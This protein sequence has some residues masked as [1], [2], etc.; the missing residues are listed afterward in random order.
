MLALALLASGC[1][2]PQPCVAVSSADQTGQPVKRYDEFTRVTSISSAFVLT[3]DQEW[4]LAEER[5]TA[6][7]WFARASERRD[8]LVALERRKSQL[9]AG[10]R[11]E[12]E[13]IATRAQALGE[14]A[15]RLSTF[16]DAL[17]GRTETALA[18]IPIQEF[19]GVLDWPVRGRV[20]SGFGPRVDPASPVEPQRS[21]PAVGRRRMARRRTSGSAATSLP[22]GVL[23]GLAGLLEAVLLRF[24]LAGV[25]REEPGLLEKRP[26]LGVEL[27]E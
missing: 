26:L 25:A 1:R 2:G 10:T 4:T 12:S 15:R 9:L 20:T 24:L 23:R 19:R 18:G 14:R 27:D 22:L 3:P 21:E 16:L 7:A 13:R 11:A 17:Y 6:R 8:Q 5:E